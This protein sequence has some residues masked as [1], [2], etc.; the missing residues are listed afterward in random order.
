[1]S[2][3]DVFKT[4]PRC[5]ESVKVPALGGS[6]P[7]HKESKAETNALMTTHESADKHFDLAVQIARDCLKAVLYINAGA[8][9]ALIALTDKSNGDY[10][11]TKA[12]LAF[13]IGALFAVM[14]FVF[15]YFSQLHYAN[16]TLEIT[17]ENKEAATDAHRKHG[18]F[19]ILAVLSGGIGGSRFCCNR[20]GNRAGRPAPDFQQRPGSC[21]ASG[22]DRDRNI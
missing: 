4:C 9:G 10:N 14:A 11:Y 12:I 18:R 21:C 2:D 8:A 15:G 13:G 7:A 5:A 6:D 16:S 3:S 1:M 22:A 17:T 19:Q 20:H